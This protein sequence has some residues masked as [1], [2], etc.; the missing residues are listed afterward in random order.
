MGRVVKD[1]QLQTLIVRSSVISKFS[2]RS[3]VHTCRSNGHSSCWLPVS[4]VE[5]S[6]MIGS[7]L[8]SATANHLPT[9]LDA[10]LPSPAAT[11]QGR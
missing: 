1:L 3:T 7:A 5:T 4:V 9:L 11:Q 10:S 2:I 6:A 8:R